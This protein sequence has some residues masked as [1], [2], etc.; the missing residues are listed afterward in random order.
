MPMALRNEKVYR[1]HGN[2]FNANIFLVGQDRVNDFTDDSDYWDAVRV[3]MK[4]TYVGEVRNPSL[5]PLVGDFSWFNAFDPT[6]KRELPEQADWHYRRGWY[7]MLFVDGTVRFERIYKGNLSS[8][9]YK[10]IPFDL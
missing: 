1:L 6:M 5:V 3:R 10:V 8:D 2:S 4:K 9:T 7:N